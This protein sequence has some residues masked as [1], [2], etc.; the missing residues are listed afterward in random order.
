ML[1][2]VYAVASGAYNESM[3]IP[4]TIGDV[5]RHARKARGWSQRDL[6]RA[7]AQFEIQQTGDIDPNTVSAVERNPYVSSVETVWRLLAA[8]GLSW[9]EVERQAGW[10]FKQGGEQSIDALAEKQ[11]AIFRQVAVELP[12]AS[13][14]EQLRRIE[15]LR[16]ERGLLRK[17]LPTAARPVTVPPVSRRKKQA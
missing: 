13:P 3:P 5:I 4:M 10:P 16:A 15:T 1:L 8:V 11:Y 7:A 12:D 14:D 9:T 2:S 6:G 17:S